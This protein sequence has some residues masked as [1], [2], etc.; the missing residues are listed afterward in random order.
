MAPLC[1][2]IHFCTGAALPGRGGTT[3]PPAASFLL[4][5]TGNQN[6]EGS[7]SDALARLGLGVPQVSI[8]DD[9]FIFWSNRTCELK[10]PLLL[11]PW[12]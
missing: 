3:A 11:L 12:L 5:M 2:D 6:F 9:L 7:M 8:Y 1:M 10:S 4:Q